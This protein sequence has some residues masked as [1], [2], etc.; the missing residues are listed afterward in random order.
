MC[1]NYT[2]MIFHMY[3]YVRL[4]WKDHHMRTKSS[5]WKQAIS[6][7]DGITPIL[8]QDQGINFV[9]RADAVAVAS[10]PCAKVHS[11]WGSIN[12]RFPEELAGHTDWSDWGVT[13][14]F[15]GVRIPGMFGQSPQDTR[16][17][18]KQW[19]PTNNSVWVGSA[20]EPVEHLPNIFCQWKIWWAHVRS[21]VSHRSIL[22]RARNQ[23]ETTYGNVGLSE[24][25]TAQHSMLDHH[26]HH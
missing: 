25:S 21:R 5:A 19:N 6:V 9:S 24:Y 20:V 3:P 23:S 13:G 1:F 11:P 15:E 16:N 10:W 4:N 14:M 2:S 8:R 7:D 17:V 12:E 26:F 22:Y 18:W